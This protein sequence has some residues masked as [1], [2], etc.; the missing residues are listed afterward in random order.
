MTNGEYEFINLC[1]ILNIRYERIVEG[2]DKSPDFLIY[3]NDNLIYIEIKD[4]ETNPD[5]KS[6]I[7]ELSE[8]DFAVWGNSKPGNRIRQKIKEGS[9]Q[10]RKYCANKYPSIIIIHDNRSSQV[11]ILSEYEIKTGMYGIEHRTLDKTGNIIKRFGSD[12]RLTENHGTY[13]S[14]V[15]ILKENNMLDLY[16][17]YF[18]D[19]PLDHHQLKQFKGVKVYALSNDPREKFAEWKKL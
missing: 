18:S 13:I 1:S 16:L 17:N 15:G 14:A 5:E 9:V 19:I 6:A 12:R 10:L 3:L 8:N 11:S 4:L 7:N 2:K